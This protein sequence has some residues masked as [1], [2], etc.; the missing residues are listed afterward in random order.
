MRNN[1]ASVV[2]TLLLGGCISPRGSSD[3]NIEKL[4]RICEKGVKVYKLYAGIVICK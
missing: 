1:I 2:A 4:P 3:L